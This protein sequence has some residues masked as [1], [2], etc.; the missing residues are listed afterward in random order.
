MI[1]HKTDKV[2]EALLPLMISPKICTDKV[3]RIYRLQ[4]TDFINH[5]KINKKLYIEYI[6]KYL[7]NTIFSSKSCFEQYNLLFL[8]LIDELLTEEEL[9]N[10]HN[11][12]IFKSIIDKTMDCSDQI[13]CLVLRLGYTENISA[14]IGK[15]NHYFHKMKQTS[16]ALELLVDNTLFMSNDDQF[17]QTT[18][19]LFHSKVPTTNRYSLGIV[20]QILSNKLESNNLRTIIPFKQY[21]RWMSYCTQLINQNEPSEQ[22]DLLF[23]ELKANLVYEKSHEIP[24]K[25]IEIMGK[26]PKLLPRIIEELDL[27]LIKYT[28]LSS[29]KIN[30]YKILL[31]YRKESLRDLLVTYANIDKNQALQQSK[32]ICDQSLKIIFEQINMQTLRQS[33]LQNLV[34]FSEYLLTNAETTNNLSFYL[35]L[36]NYLINNF[37]SQLDL[38]P[39][40]QRTTLRFVNLNCILLTFLEL[41]L[42]TFITYANSPLINLPAINQMNNEYSLLQQQITLNIFNLILDQSVI[43]FEYIRNT[44]RQNVYQTVKTISTYITALSGYFDDILYDGNISNTVINFGMEYVKIITEALPNEFG[45]FTVVYSADITLIH[46]L[47]KDKSINTNIKIALFN[48]GLKITQHIRDITLFKATSSTQTQ[49]LYH[50]NLLKIRSSKQHFSTQLRLLNNL[51]TKAQEV[52]F[53]R[54][55]IIDKP[56]NLNLL[57]NR[58]TASVEA[59]LILRIQT[60]LLCHILIDPNYIATN[61]ALSII[62]AMDCDK[63][64]S[65]ISRHYNSLSITELLKNLLSK[66]YGDDDHLQLVNSIEDHNDITQLILSIEQQFINTTTINDETLILIEKIFSGLVSL[67]LYDLA[68]KL[69]NYVEMQSVLVTAQHQS[70]I[71]LLSDYINLVNFQ[72]KS[73]SDHTIILENRLIAASNTIEILKIENALQTLE[74]KLASSHWTDISI[75]IDLVSNKYAEIHNRDLSRIY[76]SC[77]YGMNTYNLTAFISSILKMQPGLLL[78]NMEVRRHL[79]IFK[80]IIDKIIDEIAFDKDKEL[81][82]LHYFRQILLPKKIREYILERNFELYNRKTLSVPTL[83]YIED[84]LKDKIKQL[85]NS[86]KESLPNLTRLA[87]I[88]QELKDIH[89]LLGQFNSVTMYETL[90]FILNQR[91]EVLTS[92]LRK[93]FDTVIYAQEITNDYRRYFITSCLHL[94]EYLGNNAH[95][96][97]P[98][99]PDQLILWWAYVQDIATKFNLIPQISLVEV[100]TESKINTLSV[101]TAD[102][103]SST[104]TEQNDVQICSVKP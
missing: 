74:M 13:K 103:I 82:Q 14:N 86:I 54:R 41:Q 35:S 5:M 48:I 56:L 94:A 39:H 84:D 93:Y 29:S 79:L 49:S 17:N 77:N 87:E 44:E 9:N 42:N 78:S 36:S 91:F 85:N 102:H 69:F 96:F 26:H 23:V 68:D 71:K 89:T 10:Y 45:M 58:I 76:K 81:F 62:A 31:F 75:A 1:K 21:E 88:I 4:K 99:K 30:I 95:L 80:N 27:L 37:K 92:Y 40:N 59:T 50:N 3:I 47:A 12:V 20:C 25:I 7:T 61:N 98:E 38:F 67:G 46:E 72:I 65:L 16:E 55:A 101:I 18:A 32:N 43:C 90:L 19:E 52:T 97:A 53:F 70:L 33:D 28:K 100:T 64:N 57:K 15:S 2:T 51:F 104:P 63:D 73:Y 34:Y 11:F 22:L 24:I 83:R 66:I 60:P 6:L 8:E